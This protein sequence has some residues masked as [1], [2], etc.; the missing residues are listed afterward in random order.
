V[1]V[2]I[3]DVLLILLVSLGEFEVRLYSVNL[4]WVIV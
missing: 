4:L 3:Y 1:L 2:L